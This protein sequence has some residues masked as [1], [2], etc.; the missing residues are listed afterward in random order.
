MLLDT[1]NTHTTCTLMHKILA[2]RAAASPI[3][4][5]QQR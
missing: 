1:L 3:H 4:I 5:L 2:A